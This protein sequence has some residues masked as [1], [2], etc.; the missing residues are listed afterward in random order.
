[1]WQQADMISG[2]PKQTCLCSFGSTAEKH[3]WVGGGAAGIE[4]TWGTTAIK[5]DNGSWKRYRLGGVY[6]SDVVFL[7]DRDVIACGAMLDGSGNESSNDKF[8]IIMESKDSGNTWTLV[9]RSS[10][11]A[12]INKLAN[13]GLHDFYAVGDKG[14]I[15]HFKRI[16]ET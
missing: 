7:S 1:N 12:S 2:E 14:I 15:L 16:K 6:F 13:I 4:G 10:R 3:L 9:Y 11:I 8:G 5:Q